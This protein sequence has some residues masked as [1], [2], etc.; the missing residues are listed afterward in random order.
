MHVAQVTTETMTLSAPTSWERRV[1]SFFAWVPYVTLAGSAVLGVVSSDAETNGVL[2][3]ALVGVAAVWTWVTF[4]RLAAPTRVPQAMVRLYFGGFV[5]IAAA[6]VMQQ[7]VFL[8]YGIT[9]F[10][11]AAL[12]RPWPLAFLGLGA[13]ALVVHS[14]I[15]VTEST[16]A[17]WSI[18]A[19]VVL[20]Q[21]F[22]VG[23]GLYGGE[24][25][26]GIAEERR[27]AL[28]QLELAMEENA[29]LHDQLV[30]QARE[31]GVLDERQR[32]AREIHDTIAQGLT[33]VITQLEAAQQSWNDEAEMRR[34]LANAAGLARSSLA[35]ARRSVQAIRPGPLDRSRLPDALSEV[36]DR[37]SSVSGVAASMRIVGETRPLA[38]H[39]EVALLRAAQEALANTAKHAA[40]SRA[41][42]TL[43]FLS[44]SVSLDVRDDGAGFDPSGLPAAQS[45]GLAG[46]AQRIERAGGSLE[47]ESAP[48]EGTALSINIPTELVAAAHA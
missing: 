38:P 35:E 40:A 33:G 48:L 41:G 9:G 4:T 37:W 5:V 47:I 1:D 34:H 13:T 45:Y 25:I 16:L 29:G 7:A 44:G 27:A 23:F 3:P 8:A 11:H 14:N 12:L 6:L 20:V 31:A 39:V 22:A 2:V 26:A 17:S 32:M 43:T 15:V 24:R 36:T 21:T 28:E 46:M 19:G 10:F 30:A 42:V 18:Y